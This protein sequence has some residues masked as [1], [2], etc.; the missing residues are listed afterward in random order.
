MFGLDKIIAVGLSGVA[1]VGVLAVMWLSHDLGKTRVD[2]DRWKGVAQTWERAAKG[3]KSAFESSEKRRQAEHERA[4]KA[5]NEANGFC[6]KRVIQARKDGFSLASLLNKEPK[7]EPNGCAIR[8]LL[9]A[10]E[11]RQYIDAPAA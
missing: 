5:T 9:P 7:R 11:L 1:L 3:Y 4:V 6:D 8:A 2:R 10:D